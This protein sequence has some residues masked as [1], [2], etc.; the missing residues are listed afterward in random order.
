MLKPSYSFQNIIN[1]LH[2]CSVFS[3]VIHSVESFQLFSQ[4]RFKSHIDDILS[5]LKP[6]FHMNDVELVLL[7]QEMILHGFFC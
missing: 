1:S 5:W 6:V 7:K 4:F 3:C 2:N